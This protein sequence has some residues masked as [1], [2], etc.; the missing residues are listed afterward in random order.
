MESGGSGRERLGD[1]ERGGYRLGGK[2]DGDGCAVVRMVASVVD[3]NY[4]GDVGGGRLVEMV[5]MRC[6]CSGGCG[7]KVMVKMV[8]GVRRLLV[9]VVGMVMVSGWR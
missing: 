3:I 9:A 8:C 1:R 4:G 5:V 2:I 7:A 6:S